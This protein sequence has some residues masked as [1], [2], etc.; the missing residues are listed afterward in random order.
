MATKVKKGKTWYWKD[1]NGM[2]VPRDLIPEDERKADKMVE[3][4][5]GRVQKFQDKMK[6]FKEELHNEISAYLKELSAKYGEE[7]IESPTIYNYNK[8]QQVELKL[9]K[10]FVFNEMFEIAEQKIMKLIRTWS[11]GSRKELIAVIEK[12]FQKNKKGYRNQKKLFDLMSLKIDDADWIEAMDI[13]KQSIQIDSTKSY[14]YFRQ[15]GENG[16]WKA[17]S[18][19]FSAI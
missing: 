17:I 13:L 11:E 9:A 3:R 7:T 1:H 10:R 15:K 16:K 6:I 2:F 12:K 18:L 19:N 4:I 5:V 8:T 14:A